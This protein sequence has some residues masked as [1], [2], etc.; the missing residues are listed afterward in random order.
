MKTVNGSHATVGATFLR[1]LVLPLL[2]SA[3]LLTSPAAQAGWDEGLAAHRAKNYALALQEFQPLAEQG[4]MRAQRALGIM[5]EYGQGVSKDESAAVGWFRKAAEQGDSD[6]QSR[7]GG[8][9]EDG[10]GVAK[11]ERAAATWFR[12]AAEHGHATAQ[13]NLALMLANGQGVAK[14]ERAAVSWYRKAAEQGHVSAQTNLGLML[15]KGRGVAKDEREAVTWYRKAAEQGDVLAQ[16]NLGSTYEVG[17][18][19][20]QDYV[21]AARWYEAAARAGNAWGQRNLG[22]LLRKGQGVAQNLVQAHAWLNLAASMD[23]PHPNAAE[24]RDALAG[25]LT[26]AQLADAQRLAREW[27]PGAAMGAPRVKV[28]GAPLPAPKVVAASTGPYPPAPAARPGVV[29]CSTRC[30]NGDCYR[31][32]A[33]GRKTNFQAQRKYNA[34]NNQWEFDAG[35]C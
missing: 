12:K 27:K 1:T 19:A 24:E 22:R 30:N 33:D 6:A 26:P 18:G 23:E 28:V 32:Y 4:D 17:T 31:T 2:T 9:L 34:L 13:F 16:N 7:L 21:E 10:R 29:T 5:F 11:D 25:E 20:R 3:L 15:A 35:G 14:D 8:M